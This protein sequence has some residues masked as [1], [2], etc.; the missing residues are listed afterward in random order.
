MREG[1]PGWFYVGNGQLRYKDNAG[2][3][4]QYEDLDGT[5]T[6]SDVGP[7]A[8]PDLLDPATGEAV[9]GPRAHHLSTFTRRCAAVAYRLIARL[10]VAG[11][12]LIVAGWRLIV[13]GYRWASAS[14]SRRA[15]E[16]RPR[17]RGK[18]AQR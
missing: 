5:A 11:W 16:R 10:I 17:H 12:R 4:D 2:W 6:T 3:T 9:R 8:S 7:D 1:E 15:T 18:R 14:A 13:A